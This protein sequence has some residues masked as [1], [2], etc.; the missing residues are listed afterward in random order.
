MKKFILLL[1][2]FY[3]FSAIAQSNTPEGSNAAL[4]IGDPAPSMKVRWIKGQPVEKFEKGMVY[5][6]EFWAT[7]CVPCIQAMPHISELANNY[8]GKA[9]FIG[10]SV[11]ERGRPGQTIHALVD[12]FVKKNADKM[13]YT[14]CMDGSDNFM[15]SNWVEA[16]GRSSIPSTIIIDKEG[17]VAW[18]GQPTEMDQPLA[19]IIEGTF[20]SKV[21]ASQVNGQVEKAAAQRKLQE[22]MMASIKP[23]DDAL[24]AKDY[25][26]ALLE[27]EK[28]IARNPMYKALLSTHYYT[29]L[30]HL[31]PDKVYGLAMALKDSVRTAAPFARVFGTEE[32][33]P[34]KFYQYTIDFYEKNKADVSSV[35]LLG[36]A[37]YKIGNPKKAVEYQQK[38]IDWL[39]A[40]KAP[41]PADYVEAQV[42]L[43]KKYQQASE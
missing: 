41:A 18:V 43:L 39:N 42:M 22:V 38:W 28:V 25:Q 6:L 17:L 3:T 7:W 29:A 27:Y 24:R 34:N 35:Q 10:V 15:V 14:V 1:L 23:V 30:V 19:K 21:F 32:N 40:A 8:K 20:D 5:V 9:T 11:W 33:L 2:A 31:D 37:Y 12:E 26:G 36:Q 13:R 4:K 16:A